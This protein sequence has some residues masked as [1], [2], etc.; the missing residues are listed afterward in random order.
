MVRDYSK[1]NYTNQGSNE[2][3]SENQDYKATMSA[4]RT[5]GFSPDEISSIWQ[6]VAAILHLGNITFESKIFSFFLKQ[7]KK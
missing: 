6:I 2:I 3:L 4:F 7:N 5:L 1:Y